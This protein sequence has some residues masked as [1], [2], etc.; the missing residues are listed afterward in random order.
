MPRRAAAAMTPE[1]AAHEAAPLSRHIEAFLEMMAAERGAARNTLDSYGR[2]LRDF[3]AY[4]RRC[5]LA[6]EA[7]DAAAVRGYL[8]GLA[9][10][11]L[12]PRT[13]ARRSSSL[14]QFFRFL[15]ADGVREDDPMALIDRPRGGLRLPKYLSEEEVDRLLVAAHDLPE[16]EGLRLVT[17]MEVLYATGLRVSE[18]V[19]LPLSALSRDGHV[20]IVRGKGGRERTVPL[21]DPAIDSLARYRRTLQKP[22]SGKSHSPWLFPSRSRSGHLTR[23]RFAQLLKELA[24]AASLDPARVSPH[25]IRHSFASHLLAHGADLR[26]LQQMLGHADIST[27]Q[28]YTHIQADRLQSLVQRSHP[29]ARRKPG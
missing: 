19:A 8:A 4:A 21:T 3:A 7:A 27:T 24:I 26:S 10:A 29:L 14:S 23:A 2:D 28:I 6:P 5:G 15:L 18:L 11:G 13:A 1:A 17:L 25:V 9:A 20:L 22:E 16:P 12:S